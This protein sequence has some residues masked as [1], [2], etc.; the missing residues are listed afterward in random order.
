METNKKLAKRCE[1]IIFKMFICL[2]QRQHLQ[3][4]TRPSKPLKELKE[5]TNKRKYVFVCLFSMSGKMF[6]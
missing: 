2:I 6:I 3:N 4:T 1:N 5:K